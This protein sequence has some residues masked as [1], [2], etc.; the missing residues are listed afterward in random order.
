MTETT[1]ECEHDTPPQEPGLS[2]DECQR[3]RA[4]LAQFDQIG[5]MCPVARQILS[6]E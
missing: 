2:A 1:H 4:M 6:D 3:V 5:R